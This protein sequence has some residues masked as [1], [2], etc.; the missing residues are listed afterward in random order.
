MVKIPLWKYNIDIVQL[1]WRVEENNIFGTIVSKDID[2]YNQDPDMVTISWDDGYTSGNWLSPH[3]LL[4]SNV[5]VVL[6]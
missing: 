4:R 2:V 5:F 3:P 6:C 1:G